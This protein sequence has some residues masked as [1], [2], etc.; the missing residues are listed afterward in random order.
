MRFVRR[1]EKEE[2]CWKKLGATCLS[3]LR[4]AVQ[5]D[6]ACASWTSPGDCKVKAHYSLFYLLPPP[7]SPQGTMS[8]S[9]IATVIEW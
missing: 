2:D 5:Q 9:E 1:F 8:C 7:H 4:H 3:T 6:P